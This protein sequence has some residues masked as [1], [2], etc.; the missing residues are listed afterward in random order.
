VARAEILDWV[1]YVE[2][3]EAIRAEALAAKA[4]RRVHVGEYLTFLFENAA[5]VRYQVQEMMRVERLV[6]EADIEHELAT[7]NALLG[8]DG[9]LGC[10]LL[11]EIEDETERDKKLR[12]WLE[13]PESVYLKLENGEKVRAAVDPEQRSR[14]RLSTVQYL[15]FQVRDRV[16][17]AIGCDH[18]AF[19]LE[20]VLDAAQRAALRADLAS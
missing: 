16:P 12:E 20:T 18:P 7:Y 8:G 9:E 17:T 10:T 11:V 3:R 13:L 14:G 6:R 2:R 1:T 5:T 4:A 15:R 19:G